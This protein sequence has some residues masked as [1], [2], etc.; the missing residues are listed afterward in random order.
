MGVNDWTTLELRYEDE[1]I[2]LKGRP[3]GLKSSIVIDPRIAFGAPSI[4]G[5]PTWVIAGREAAGETVE[6]IG[7]D[8]DLD[9]DE[10]EE[11]LA[12]ERASLSSEGKWNA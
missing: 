8:F 10:V 11:A 5:T 2:A 9:V 3:R 12:F 7:D 6:E 1:G 4:N